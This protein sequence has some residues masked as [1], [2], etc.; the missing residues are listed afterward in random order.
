MSEPRGCQTERGWRP[1]VVLSLHRLFTEDDAQPQAKTG[2]DM[3]SF[4]DSEPDTRM[5]R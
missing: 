4:E 2:R 3:E 1:M 5:T